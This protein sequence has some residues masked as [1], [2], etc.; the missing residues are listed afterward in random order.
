MDSIQPIV[1]ARIANITGAQ[2]DNIDDAF[3]EVGAFLIWSSIKSPELYREYQVYISNTLKQ[4]TKNIR[5]KWEVTDQSLDEI[6]CNIG[7]TFLE[8]TAY[9][10]ESV[11]VCF[12]WG[13]C[14][15]LSW[16]V[17]GYSKVIADLIKT[18]FRYTEFIH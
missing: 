12:S 15:E 6:L 2:E 14:I 16:A 13:K 17:P 8:E 11:Q 5:E 3:L 9:K 10:T 4:E 18:D 7:F 1:R